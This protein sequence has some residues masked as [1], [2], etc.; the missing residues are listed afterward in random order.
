ML[1]PLGKIIALFK[2]CLKGQKPPAREG[3]HVLKWLSRKA[4]ADVYTVWVPTVTKERS[5]VDALQV[6]V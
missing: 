3:D 1:S 2:L 5:D 4:G 6:T